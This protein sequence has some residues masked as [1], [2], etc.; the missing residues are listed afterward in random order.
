MQTYSGNVAYN[1]SV[2]RRSDPIPALIEK[3]AIS[4][5]PQRKETHDRPTLKLFNDN[6]SD[7]D[8]L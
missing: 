8:L 4:R 2:K 3:F 7:V 1:A 5:G 6:V